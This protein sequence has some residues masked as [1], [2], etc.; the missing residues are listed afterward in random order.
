MGF[1]KALIPK[2]HQFKICDK[3]EQK[4]EMGLCLLICFLII[5][6]RKKGSY[7]QVVQVFSKRWETLTDFSSNVF[8][9]KLFKF[10]KQTH[11]N[12]K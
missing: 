3:E 7:Y 6:W 12:I 10:V 11:K 4:N 2:R 5:H 1:F 9:S 8:H